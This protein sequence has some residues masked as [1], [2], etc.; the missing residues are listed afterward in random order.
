MAASRSLAWHRASG[1]SW[2]TPRRARNTRNGRSLSR[3]ARPSSSISPSRLTTDRLT[4]TTSASRAPA[5]RGDGADLRSLLSVGGRERSVG[6]PVRRLA[7]GREPR[8]VAGAVP[9]L[10]V[11]VPMHDAA[12]VGAPRRPLV[13][14][15]V[16][17]AVDR[18]QLRAATQHGAAA[19]RDLRHRLHLPLGAGDPLGGVAGHRQVAAHEGAAGAQRLAPRV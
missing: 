10:V 12:E 15:A 5:E 19:R 3:K 4:L 9:A 1:R 7:G 18:D 14:G 11:V 2:R 17:A 13:Q 6:G 8:A 16:L